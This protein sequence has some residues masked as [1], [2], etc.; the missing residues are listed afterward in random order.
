MQ[1]PKKY[2]FFRLDKGTCGC[3]FGKCSRIE[4]DKGHKDWYEPNEPEHDK[5]GL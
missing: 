2:C 3:A 4:V 1:C 5:S